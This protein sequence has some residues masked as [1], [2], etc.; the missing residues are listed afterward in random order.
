VEAQLWDTP[1]KERYRGVMGAYYGGAHGVVLVY[2]TTRHATFEACTRWVD[3]LRDHGVSAGAV[4]LVGNKC[5]LGQLRA[6]TTDEGRAFAN[7]NGMSFM[8]VSAL[9]GTSVDLAFQI[10]LT[11]VFYQSEKGVAAPS[12]ASGGGGGGGAA[13][14]AGGGGGGRGSGSGSGSGTGSTPPRGASTPAMQHRAGINNNN[15][16]NNNPHSQQ[17]GAGMIGGGG[18][19]GSSG[20]PHLQHH[21]SMMHHGG[22]NNGNNYNH[23]N[24][25]H[26]NNNN[27]NNTSHLHHTKVGGANTSHYAAGNMSQFGA[28]GAGS[29]EIVRSY[30]AW[31]QE[32]RR[33]LAE[34]TERAAQREQHLAALVSRASHLTSECDA[35][36]DREARTASDVRELEERLA[37]CV[38]FFSF[39]FLLMFTQFFIACTWEKN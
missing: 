7:A 25:P 16:N 36:R 29:D 14:A 28:G 34:L 2:D 38:E 32:N 10:L 20:G 24:N 8:E 33:S 23:N 37:R 35:A 31:E 21:Q 30:M 17:G 27:N 18:G 19:G 26:N 39:F 3:D 13:A 1:G 5:D 15:N 9:D 6:V 4:M 12:V 11:E 22:G